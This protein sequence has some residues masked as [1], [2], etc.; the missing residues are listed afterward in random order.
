MAPRS[1]HDDIRL[2][3]ATP[4]AF[5]GTSAVLVNGFGATRIGTNRTPEI[6]SASLPEGDE[7]VVSR[8]GELY[9]FQFA[10]DTVVVERHVYEGHVFRA[11]GA[12]LRLALGPTPAELVKVVAGHDGRLS[13]WEDS[14]EA[15]RR[16]W[17]IDRGRAEADPFQLNERPS[18]DLVIDNGRYVV[19][20]EE[21][22]VGGDRIRVLD[23]M[24]ELSELRS[25]VAVTAFD[26]VVVPNATVTADLDHDHGLHIFGNDGHHFLPTA[27]PVVDAGGSR[28]FGA[29]VIFNGNDE[30]IL[31]VVR[32][33]DGVWGLE[34]VP[35][36]SGHK[37]LSPDGA[38]CVSQGF[39][40]DL[41]AY[42]LALR[43]RSPARS[44]DSSRSRLLVTRTR[45]DVRGT[46]IHLH[47]GP[48]SFEAPE[49][50]MFGLP[51]F[52]NVSGWDWIGVNYAGSLSP[53][54][55]DTRQAWRNWR[56]S[57]IN[58]LA[59][60]VDEARGPVALVGWSFGAALA[61]A[62]ASVSHRIRGLLLGGC[63][64]DLGAHV[65][66]ACLVD[67]DH[68]DWFHLRFDLDGD[69][70]DFFNGVSGYRDDI[71]VLEIHGKSDVQCPYEL[72]EEVAARWAALGNPW[73]Q[74]SIPS[75]S[76]Y[77]QTMDDAELLIRTART[78]LSQVFGA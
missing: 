17:T 4:I 41:T 50:R 39:S 78:F 44:T 23:Q 73:G 24:G 5:D 37:T 11:E 75:G 61:L 19:F 33:D 13:L 47:G 22:G 28:S 59:E 72:M 63:P 36:P 64:G 51:Q 29:V 12:P 40:R 65:A 49:P 26:A 57:V 76:H 68:Q 58:D 18:G 43:P 48:E 14:A 74:V 60:A 27:G 7:V 66:R 31:A 52:S 55:P 6:E 10:E 30:D 77:A 46:V 38:V 70:G 3:R 20:Y 67:P 32:G 62:G 34:A 9:S 25:S 8:T 45:L 42:A 21:G 71:K 69:D 2:H 15:C 1:P 35:A 16:L 54:L 53:R 56:E